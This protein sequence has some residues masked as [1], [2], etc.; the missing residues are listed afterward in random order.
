MIVGKGR[1]HATRV[2]ALALAAGVVAALA[3]SSSTASSRLSPAAGIAEA[4]KLVTQYEQPP[5]W[6][7]PGTPFDA[8]KA[9]GK[10]IWYVSL[11]LSIPFEQ[12]ML[13]G[14]QQGAKSVGA[15][16]VGFDG[17]FSAAEGSRGIEQV[18]Y[19]ASLV[20]AVAF[21]RLAGRRGTG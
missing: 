7:P 11:S 13:Q 16:G 17:K 2:T 19:G 21:S 6:A 3:A 5:K 15:K 4:K 10:S 18:F 20:L 1:G 8:S 12:Y 9:K 14:I